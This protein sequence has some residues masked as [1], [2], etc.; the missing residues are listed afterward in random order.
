MGYSA[1][2]VLPNSHPNPFNCRVTPRFPEVMSLL[3]E[4]R[5]RWAV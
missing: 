5:E 1:A 4:E 3:A 2:D